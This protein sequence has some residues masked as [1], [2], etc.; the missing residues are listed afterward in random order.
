MKR[1]REEK[2]VIAKRRK[3]PGKIFLPII[4]AMIFCCSLTAFAYQNITLSERVNEINVREKGSIEIELTDGGENISKEDVVFRYA[5]V[6]DIK[7]GQYVLKEQ[8]KNCGVDLNQI[9]YAKELDEAAEK[10]SYYGESDGDCITNEEGIAKIED[11]DVGVYLLYVSEQKNYEKVMPVLIAVP[12]WEEEEGMM[13]YNVKVFPKHTPIASHDG[14][15]GCHGRTESPCPHALGGVDEHAE[16][17][18]GGSYFSR[19]NL[20]INFVI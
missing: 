11:L 20:Y 5:K 3:G 10:L 8:Y 9:S 2:A 19:T 6:A 13:L 12:T 1:N 14:D 7:D 4:L 16:G 17:A 18:G 15:C